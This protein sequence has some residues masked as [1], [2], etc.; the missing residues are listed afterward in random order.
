M[1][2]EITRYRRGRCR[3]TK[4]VLAK[5]IHSIS[6]PW[7]KIDGVCLSFQSITPGESFKVDLTGEVLR[8]I[9]KQYDKEAEPVARI[10]QEHLAS[11][12]AKIREGVA[13][14]L[15]VNGQ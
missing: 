9:V 10:S 4:K 6:G 3:C 11:K 14:A 12:L 1:N 7:P 5:G 8:A 13:L 2:I 15:E